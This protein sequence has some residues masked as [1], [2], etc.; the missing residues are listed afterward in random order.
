MMRKMKIQIA[1]RLCFSLGL[2]LIIALAAEQTL[3]K[4]Q[5]AIFLTNG[6]R[7]I[8]EFVDISA[9]RLV[10]QLKYDIEIP[11]SNIWMINFMDKNWYFP[12]ELKKMVTPEHYLFLKNGDIVTGEV[13]DFND[14][15]QVF[16]LDG[17]GKVEIGKLSRIYFSSKI[18]DKLAA[19]LRPPEKKG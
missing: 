12:E 6:R 9:P 3:E 15:L 4:D 13:V 16:E 14:R 19:T 17:G 5:Q 10:L 1:I 2:F 7:V 18:P 11:L 8:G